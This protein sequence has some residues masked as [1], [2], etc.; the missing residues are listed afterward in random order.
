M[1]EERE[2]ESPGVVAVHRNPVHGFAKS[3]AAVIRLLEGQ[4]VEGDAHCGALVKH[5]SRVAADPNQPNLRQVHLLH[6]EC[7][8]ELAAQGFSLHPG[9]IGENVTTAGVRLSAL[10]RGALLHLGDEA[11]VELTGLRNPCRQLDDFAPGLMAAMV[12]RAPDGRLLR[13]AGVMAVVRRGG[14]VRPGD[15]IGI[16][17]PRAPHVALEKV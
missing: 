17:W 15:A 4:G 2:V 5:R 14:L 8:A 12:A 6:A 16:T 1:T 3:P 11:V 10:P 13:K 7:F 9:A